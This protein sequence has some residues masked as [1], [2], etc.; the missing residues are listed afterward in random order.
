M[1]AFAVNVAP[2]CEPMNLGICD[3]PPFVFPRD[4]LEPMGD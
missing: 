4:R 3:F 2:G 1:I